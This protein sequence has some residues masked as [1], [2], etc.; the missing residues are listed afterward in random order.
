MP[1]TLCNTDALSGIAYVLGGILSFRRVLNHVSWI[2]SYAS[3]SMIHPWRVMCGALRST[4]DAPCVVL[5]VLEI[6]YYARHS[7][8][9]MLY[10]MSCVLS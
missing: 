9:L 5:D 6:V 4:N 3:C 7:I 2:M 1:C 10:I 8:H